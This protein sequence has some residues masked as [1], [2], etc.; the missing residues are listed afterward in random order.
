MSSLSSSSHSHSF[1]F[2]PFYSAHKHIDPK[3]LAWFI[4]FSEGDGGLHVSRGHC[5]FGITQN[6]ESVLQEIKSV[7]GFGRVY[8]DHSANCFRYRVSTAAEVLKLALLFNGNLAT[9]NKIEQLEKWIEALNKKDAN[10]TFICRPFLPTLNDGWLSGFTD[11]EGC[12]YV[13][14]IKQKSKS[15]LV[16]SEGVAV[17]KVYNRIVT[18][19]V[20]D[21][22]EETIL[23]HIKTLFGFG[24]VCKTGD[25]GVFRYVNGSY[26]AN[27]VTVD[28]YGLFPL[29]TKKQAAYLKWCD[30]RT[31]LLAKEHLSPEGLE[32]I[33]EL[34]KLINNE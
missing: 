3:W 19:F 32:K 2:D 27:Y 31:K 21:Q 33:R 16:N 11:A 10:L 24:S 15:N 5:T 20:I 17:V 25:P 23:L 26:K 12:F 9:K 22:K 28:Y 29:K 14:V 34:A 4:G 1:N 18:R 13:S 7:L 30:I 8:F 6:E